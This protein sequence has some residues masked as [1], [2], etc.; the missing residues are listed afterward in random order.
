MRYPRLAARLYGA[1]LMLLPDKARLIEEI[2]RGHMSADDFEES[3]LQRAEREQARRQVAYA[4]I[5]L[6][7]Q[8]DKPYAITSSGIALVPVLGTLV[9]RGSWMDAM[10]GLT[11]YD[12]VA[13]MMERALADPEVRA[14]LL[15]IDS[16]GGEVAG[17]MDLT[18]RIQAAAKRKPTWSVASES[19]YSAAYWIAASAEFAYVAMTGGV[20]SIG[21]VMLHVDQS[22]RDSAMGYSYTYIA[23]GSKKAAGN[24]HEPI[25]DGMLSWAQAEV[26][27]TGRLFASGVAIQRGLAVEDVLALEGGLLTPPEALD[28]GYVDGINTLIEVVALL[29]AEI[30]QPGSTGARISASRIAH[31]ETHM[32]DTTKGAAPGTKAATDATHTA[33]E[34]ETARTAARADGVKEGETTGHANGVKAERERIGGILGCEEAKERTTLAAHLALETNTDIDAAKKLLAA[35]PKSGTGNGLHTAMAQLKNPKVGADVEET[36]PVQRMSAPQDIYASRAKASVAA[37]PR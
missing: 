24:P 10:S 30:Q 8:P 13:S 7:N 15:E 4:G 36:Q 37:M 34:L 29:N 12:N 16:P 27:R 33:A 20:G 1:P 3:P 11:S 25:S 6:K 18:S 2:F 31:K 9:Q 23:S 14:I 28:A 26:D 17:I 5:E 35:S 21:A 22:K 19:A 32:S